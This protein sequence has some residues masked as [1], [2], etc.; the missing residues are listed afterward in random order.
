M[1]DLIKVR[2]VNEGI[3]IIDLDRV[4]YIMPKKYGWDVTMENGNTLCIKEIP[5]LGLIEN[6]ENE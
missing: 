6:K 4:V 2:C 5:S 1:S 3:G